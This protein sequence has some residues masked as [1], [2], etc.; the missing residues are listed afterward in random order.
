MWT[1]SVRRTFAAVVH[2][3]RLFELNHTFHTDPRTRI[4]L[5][6]FLDVIHWGTSGCV[7]C[8]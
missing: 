3:L 1:S 7:S 6:I 8:G 4:E 2:N 5:E